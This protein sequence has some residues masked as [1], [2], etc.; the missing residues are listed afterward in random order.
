M[1][2]ELRAHGDLA[3]VKDAWGLWIVDLLSFVLSCMGK[4]CSNKC[5][6]RYEAQRQN[7]TD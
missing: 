7:E 3:A 5:K 6:E 1:S 4:D 2:N